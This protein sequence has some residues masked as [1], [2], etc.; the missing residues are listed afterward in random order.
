MFDT[1]AA[2]ITG[3][4][5]TIVVDGA[6]AIG[7]A[8]VD[9][10]RRGALGRPPRPMAPPD[11]TSSAGWVART[12]PPRRTALVRSGPRSFVSCGDRVPSALRLVGWPCD[13]RRP[14]PRRAG[15]DGRR[16]RRTTARSRARGG[17]SRAGRLRDPPRG[18]DRGPALDDVLHRSLD[19]LDDN[20]TALLLGLG[21]TVDIVPI[22]L[23]Q[24]VSDLAPKEFDQRPRRP[25]SLLAL[26]PAEGGVT[27]LPPIRRSIR[28]MSVANGTAD[29]ADQRLQRWAAR[30]LQVGRR[31]VPTSDASSRA[32]PSCAR[33]SASRSTTPVASPMRSPSPASLSGA[34]ATALQ[35]RR[36]LDVLESLLAATQHA[37]TSTTPI[38]SSSSSASPRS[39]EPTSSTSRP[40]NRCST[41]P[42]RWSR[43]LR[44]RTGISPDSQQRGHRSPS[45]R[46]TCELPR[47]TPSPQRRPPTRAADDQARLG[48]HKLLAD[49]LL[50][51]GHLVEADAAAA[52]VVAE[53]TGG[54]EWLG[55]LAQ[56]LRG[57]AAV[58]SGALARA[59]AIG[60]S[61]LERA[62]RTR[63]ALPR[64]RG[65]LRSRSRRSDLEPAPRHRRARPAGRFVVV[66]RA[67]PGRTVPHH[68]PAHR[69]RL[70]GGHDP[71]RRQ[72]R[73]RRCPPAPMGGDRGSTAARRRLP[74][75][76]ASAGRRW[77]PTTRR[78]RPPFATARPSAPP[79]PSTD[80]PQRCTDD[81]AALAA[82]ASTTARHVRLHHR[83]ARRPRPWLTVPPLR[84]VPIPDGWLVDGVAT[85]DAPPRRCPRSRRSIRP[86]SAA[87]SAVC[88]PASKR[89]PAWSPPVTPTARSGRAAHLTTHRRDTHRPR[90]PQARHPDPLPPRE[91]DDVRNPRR[92]G[93]PAVP[94]RHLRG[95]VARSPTSLWT[96][97]QEGDG[98]KRCRLPGSCRHRQLDRP[99]PSCQ[100]PSASAIPSRHRLAATH[101]QLQRRRPRR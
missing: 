10:V 32:R 17:P 37:T 26:L 63:A 30:A 8:L 23:A 61:L 13:R 42:T 95:P 12:H 75:R 66:A 46:A 6:E 94:G 28:R 53:A 3:R 21:S 34:L 55:G 41:V 50:E 70:H 87:R 48:A 11:V 33:R 67:P 5:I 43:Q 7:S 18:A 65:R 100:R 15:G 83:A 74:R 84:R 92:L 80:T 24:A 2:V 51:G 91:P 9:F 20:A 88:R 72:R 69:R 56:A 79:T 99:T 44:H 89:S 52:A 64:A 96:R 82:A 76:R 1:L 57:M 29:I 81:D 22:D 93:L 73:D 90:L 40:V 71:R 101:Q 49:V 60:T 85:E 62:R 77:W 54:L 98:R 59:T 36:S 97:Q 47:P 16:G 45:T 35:H 68:V 4:A 27:V 78:S 58:D 25:R 39:A 86:D 38:S 14:S 31:R 19:L